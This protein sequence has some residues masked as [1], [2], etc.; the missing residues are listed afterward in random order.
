MAEDMDSVERR[1]CM[2][3]D[4]YNRNID[5]IR[6]S[7]TDRCNLRCRYCMPEDIS[8][9]G[10]DKILRYEEITQIVQILAQ[11]GITK[12]KITGGEPLVR[13]GC[14]DLIREIKEIPGIEM[15][16]LTTNGILLQSMLPKLLEAGVDAV[17]V[18]LD[19]FQRA[20]YEHL[21]GKDAYEMVLAGIQDAYKSGIPLKLNCVPI[22]GEN[23][24]ELSEFFSWAKRKQ[25]AVRFIEMMPIGY[26]KTYKSVPSD[27]ILRQFFEA[28]PDA[29]RLEKSLGNGP[30]VYYSAPGFAGE[31]GVIGAIHEKFCNTCNRIRLTSEGFLKTC[32]Q[33]D[34]GV[35]LKTILR[36]GG[37]DEDLRRAIGQALAEKPKGHSFEKKT[38]F[39]DREH[40]GMSQIGG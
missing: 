23:T 18:S 38:E 32:L 24:D 14:T 30:A 29:Y 15:V 8:F 12:V 19:T 35:E 26:G 11:R 6:I 9:V 40:R 20:R 39:T 33:Y 2:I 36:G 25:I 17:N 7:I 16:T 13:H 28:Y 4:H 31:I 10:H 3:T 22:E 5:Y 27:E 21:T 1:G 37:T 34:N